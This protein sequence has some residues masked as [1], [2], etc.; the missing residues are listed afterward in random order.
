MDQKTYCIQNDKEFKAAIAE[1]KAENLISDPEKCLLQYFPEKWDPKD[2]RN[3][4]D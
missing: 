1:I 3:D 2:I 4:L